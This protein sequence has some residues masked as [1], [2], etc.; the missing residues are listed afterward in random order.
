MID[1]NAGGPIGYG[2]GVI[3]YLGRIVST[4]PLFLGYFWM[5]W[6]NENQCWQDKFA[7]SIVVPVDAYPVR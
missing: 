2:R 4:I 3:R 5:L 7:G 6:D 1:L